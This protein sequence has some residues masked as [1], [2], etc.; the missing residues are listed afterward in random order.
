MIRQMDQPRFAAFV[1]ALWERQ[2]W[3]TRVTEKS[4]KSFVALQ[5]EGAEGLIWATPGSGDGV[6][7][8]ALQQF[9]T[10]REQYGLDE[11]AVVTAGRFTDDAERIAD[12]AGV[13]L[14][15]G[16]RLRTV[17]EARE[18]HDLVRE[19]ADDAVAG[20]DGT[21]NDGTAEDVDGEG[22]LDRLPSVPTRAV[23]GA[24]VALLAVVAVVVVGPTILGTGGDVQET[25]FDVSAA[26]SSGDAAT[27]RVAWNAG[28]TTE[29]R[30]GDDSVYRPR[31][32]QRFVLVRMN[33][34]NAGSGTVGLRQRGFL[35][36]ANGT[37]RGHQPLSN[38]SGFD[39]AVLAPGESTTVW[40]VFSVDESTTTATLVA[41]EAVYGDAAVRFDRDANLSV[42]V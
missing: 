11:G 6:S 16:E 41:S 25:T 23:G 2:G 31:P 33:V 14:V 29:L 4:G 3:R 40:T 7:G 38:A 20:D 36:R 19:H 22:P 18:L 34:T 39:P 21:P 5:R 13:E 10:L 42:A 8:K 1:A 28:A 27:L 30:P 37:T 32:G 15:D 9:V 26:S 12:R 35:L 17:V 24:V